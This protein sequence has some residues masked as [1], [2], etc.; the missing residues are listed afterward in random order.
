MIKSLL[1]HRIDLHNKAHLIFTHVISNSDLHMLDTLVYAPC[2]IQERIQ[3]KYEL[4]ITVIEDMVFSARLDLP[5]TSWDDIHN[6]NDGQI[7]KTPINLTG[8]DEEKCK[9]LMAS[10]GLKYGAID[11]VVDN[12]GRMVFLEVNPTGDWYWIEKSTGLPI[13]ET[14]VKLIQKYIRK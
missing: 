11:L 2:M 5:K 14:M 4:R 13:T 8:D 10:L 9:Q 3:A 12:T 6:T 1:H 7:I